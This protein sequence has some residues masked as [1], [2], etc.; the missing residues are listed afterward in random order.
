MI[1]KIIFFFIR[2]KFIV[3]MFMLA[4]IGVGI[5]F[6]FMVNLGLVLDIINN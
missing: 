1:D 5:Y 4:F 3:G 6:M 2:N